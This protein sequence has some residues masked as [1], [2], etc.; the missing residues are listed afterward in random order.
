MFSFLP[1]GQVPFEGQA[2][3][4]P[5]LAVLLFVGV[6]IIW[7]VMRLT[8]SGSR[9]RRGS[10]AP[11][12]HCPDCGSALPA[13]STD[14]LCPRCLL[15]Q[16]FDYGS[17]VDDFAA[18]AT[19]KLRSETVATPPPSVRRSAMASRGAP[20]F[21]PPEPEQLALLFPRLEI[22][23]PRARRSGLNFDTAARWAPANPQGSVRSTTPISSRS[24]NS[25]STPIP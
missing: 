11:T 22:E 24:R 6:L 5:G 18:R 3:Q 23:D 10:A 17:A 4:L 9:K 2:V 16:G 21:Q 20:A 14:D 19:R 8:R 25:P 12:P 1:I 7:W 13:H 15:G